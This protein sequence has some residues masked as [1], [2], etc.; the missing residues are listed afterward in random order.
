MNVPCRNCNAELR[1]SFVDLGPSPLANSYVEPDRVLEAEPFYSLHAYVC[2]KCFLVQLPAV[3][4]AET[5]F[6]DNYAYFSSYSDSVLAHSRAYVA[7]MMDRF[8]YGG[9]HQVVELA[10]ND[11]YLLQYFKERG[12]PVLGIEPTG[13]TAEVAI[14][15]GIP[16]RNVF[17]G[18]ETAKALVAEGIRADLIIGNNVTAHVPDVHD[19]IGGQK[20]LLKD[21]GV[22][23]LEFPHLKQMMD[24][25][26][27][28][29][30]YHEHFSYLSLYAIRD[31]FARNG[32]TV[33]DVDEIK[34]QGGSIRVYGR[35][36]ADSSK[37]VSE[38]VTRLI[39]TELADGVTSLDY[40]RR[41]AE[42]VYRSKRDLLRFLMEAKEAGKSVVGY[43]APAKGNT[44][45]N[46]CGVRTD[47][48]DYTVDRN[49]NKQNRLLPGTRIPV[50]GPEAILE[51]R[52]DYVL[53][54]PWNIRDEVM[55]QMA[56]VRT[57]GGRFVV[58][59]PEVAVLD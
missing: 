58:P 32:L 22:I 21:D 33:F 17:F 4:K 27:F 55:S 44:L 54:L 24:K 43:G 9:G 31:V 30:I 7:M 49:P 48:I 3:T 38:R 26:Y 5:I 18:V 2:D 6:S 56:E 40:Y 34:P 45:L 1:H 41:F 12:V 25:N 16:T 23:T 11:G 29:M 53:I 46:F 51:T 39:E 8:G 47:F 10:S 15:A 52:P 50:R 13:N 57:W 19:F 20:I 14:A 35:H 42:Q 28:D 37:P 36:D 59:L